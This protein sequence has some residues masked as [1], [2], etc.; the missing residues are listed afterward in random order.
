MRTK[1]TIVAMSIVLLNGALCQAAPGT[2]ADLPPEL[3]DALLHDAACSQAEEPTSGERAP[4][5]LLEAVVA[6]QDV[7]NAAGANVGVIVTFN[8]ACHC[9]DATC[10]TYVYLKNDEG[11]K[12]AFSGAFSS[13]HPVR[14]FKRGYPSLTGKVQI[15]KAQVESTVY[16][17]NGKAYAP[18]LCATITQRAG[19]RVPSIVHHDCAKAP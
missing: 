4:S 18:S 9:R 13:L 16:D 15:S 14:V 11:Y 6:T 19:R 2:V 8:D 5:R 17:W 7:R 3:R 10:G 1:L 12:L